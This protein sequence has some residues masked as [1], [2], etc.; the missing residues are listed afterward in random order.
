MKKTIL[1]SILL[2]SCNLFYGQGTSYN[3][4]FSQVLNLN[5]SASHTTNDA[6][7]FINVGTLTVPNNKVYK[8]TNGSS[9]FTDIYGRSFMAMSIKVGEH[10]LHDTRDATNSTSLVYGP[11][12]LSAGT[13]NVFIRY[14]TQA[15]GTLTGSLSA[16]EFNIE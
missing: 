4:G 13:Y 8:I 14:G 12:W 7:K 11:I 2:L 10:I 6:Y 16:V 15:N 1:I 3:L 9:Y 5:F